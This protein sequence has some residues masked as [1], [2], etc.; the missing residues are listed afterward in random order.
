MASIGEYRHSLHSQP[1][2]AHDDHVAPNRRDTSSASNASYSLETVTTAACNVLPSTDR[3]AP[4]GPWDVVGDDDMRVQV[5]VAGAGVP[6]VEGSG[7]HAA[8]PD[9]P[10]ARGTD[11]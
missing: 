11:P 10:A 8:R 7:D 3:H 1:R 4:S 5:R 6:V 2:R 9:L